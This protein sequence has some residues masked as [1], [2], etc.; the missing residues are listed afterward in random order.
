MIHLE[1]SSSVSRASGTVGSLNQ[2][3]RAPL[4]DGLNA[5]PQM[6]LHIATCNIQACTLE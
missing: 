1:A 2:D 6:P 5:K 3:P 4:S